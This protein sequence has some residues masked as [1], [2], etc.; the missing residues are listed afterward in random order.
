MTLE[1]LTLASGSSGNCAL[2]HANDGQERV[3]IALDCGIA[4]RNARNLA[5]DAG[6]LFTHVDAVLLT[7]HHGDH[8]GNI[9]ATAARAKAPLYAHPDAMGHNQK[10]SAGEVARRQVEVRPIADRL[11]FSVG[12]L[13]ITPIRVPH[14]GDPCFGFVFD[15]NGQRAAYFT[16]L[17]STDALMGST[18]QGVSA[19]VLEFNHDINMLRNGPYPRDLQNRVAGPSGHLSNAQAAG[20]L[21]QHAPASLRELGLAHLSR[22]NNTPELALAAARAGL[23]QA[24]LNAVVTQACPILRV[25]RFVATDVAQASPNN[26]PT[27]H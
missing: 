19:L 2:V 20:F 25:A 7:H 4:Q 21:A 12:P 18:L 27:L 26:K 5:Q 11:S 23:R 3:V 6:F 13:E 22:H 16:D 24:G 10:T 14:D 1:I 17:G 15:L 8:S 9:V